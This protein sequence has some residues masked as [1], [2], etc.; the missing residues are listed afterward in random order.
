V[1][2]LSVPLPRGCA[3][4]PFAA[5]PALYSQRSC[6]LD[7]SSQLRLR[8]ATRTSKACSPELSPAQDRAQAGEASAAADIG[9]PLPAASQPEEAFQAAPEPA[10]AEP[11]SQDCASEQASTA[12]EEAP[13][14][15]ESTTAAD[16][17]CAVAE[18]A[19]TAAK[20]AAAAELALAAAAAAAAAAADEALVA[21]EQASTVAV[22][23]C[24]AAAEAR[25][26]VVSPSGTRTHHNMFSHPL[27]HSQA[28]EVRAKGG[29][30]G[31]EGTRSVAAR[32]TS[33]ASSP[34]LLRSTRALTVLMRTPDSPRH[35]TERRLRQLQRWW[36]LA[37]TSQTPQVSCGRTA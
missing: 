24:A 22:E 6:A 14:A 16:E 28:V 19:S 30:G 35:P 21:L 31:R 10:A 2:R 37:T 1:T 32:R 8:F 13:T 3:C 26:Y 25:D 17:D 27:E 5:L 20:E 15:A 23:A 12:G 18:Q 4:L 11:L 34:T 29:R 33:D 36:V 9:Q 7:L